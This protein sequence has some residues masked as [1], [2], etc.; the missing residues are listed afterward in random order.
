MYNNRHYFT[1][2]GNV[3]GAKRGV[4]I[5]TSELK[6]LYECYFTEVRAELSKVSWKSV[7]LRKSARETPNAL[8]LG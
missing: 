5:R 8:A 3:Y 1:V 6:E 2:T 7:E 4:E